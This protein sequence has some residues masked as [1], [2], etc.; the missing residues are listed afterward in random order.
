MAKTRPSISLSNAALSALPNAVG[1]PKYDRAQVTPGILH[2]GLGNFHRAHQAVYLDDLMQL[3]EGLDWGIIGAGIMPFDAARRAL[4]AAQDQLTTVVEMSDAGSHARVTG[5]MIGFCDVDARALVHQIA[6]PAIRIVSLTITEGGYFVDAKTGAFDAAHPD[7]L[8]DAADL[9]TPRTVFGVLLAGLIAR[10]DAGIPA[11]TILSCDNIPENGDV[12]RNALSGLADLVSPDLGDWVRADVAFPNSM[13]DRITP[14]TTEATRAF[15]LTEFGIDDA[16]P[17][18]CE[19]FRQWVIE[20]H[21]PMGRPALENVGVTFTDDVAPFE[22]M[23]LRILNA[24]H[25]SIAYVA[26]LLGITYVHDAM[27]DPDIAA[28]L[29]TL[30][31]QEVIPTLAELPGVEYDAYLQ[32]CAERFSNPAV[33]DTIDRLCQDGSNRQPKFVLPTIADALDQG[34]AINGLALELAF[35]HHYCCTTNALDDPRSEILRA[36]PTKSFLDIAEI[37]GPLS[38]SAPLRAAFMDHAARL[39]TIGPR[40]TLKAYVEGAT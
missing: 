27:A 5:A 28:W 1:R 12:A 20:D 3:G 37:F 14:V 35:W 34:R 9:N 18:T 6:D 24:G 8:S 22:T 7:I 31:R 26:A 11:P 21:F 33:A 30:M 25:A 19:P 16:S 2:I 36:T 23:K 40:A 17:V 39:A 29:Q 38:D 10:R 15:V 13:V 32:T 4:L